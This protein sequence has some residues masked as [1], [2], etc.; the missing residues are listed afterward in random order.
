MAARCRLVALLALAVVACGDRRAT[1]NPAHDASGPR[2]D[3]SSM[4][5]EKTELRWIKRDIAS[6]RLAVDVLEG[7]PV[8]EETNAATHF[9]RLDRA[10]FQLAIWWGPDATLAA[11][12]K[13][14][15]E[16]AP[17]ATLAPPTKVTFCGAEAERQEATV[18]GLGS[19][20]ALVRGPDG[21][22]ESRRS[23]HP[24]TAVTVVIAF[25]RGDVPV[26]L[27]YSVDETRREAEREA[28]RHFF[29]SVQCE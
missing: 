23:D 6:L 29:A 4:E 22:I 28:E 17:A 7:A 11:W 21:R 20:E 9:L 12:Q 25:R 10:P 24:A 5:M 3:G 18:P 26:L 14:L 15:V 19:A 2:A 16:G 1:R 27:G 13:W 8:R